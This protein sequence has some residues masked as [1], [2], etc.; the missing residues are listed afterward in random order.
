[1]LRK[2]LLLS[3]RIGSPGAGLAVGDSGGRRLY[4]EAR[5]G[6]MSIVVPLEVDQVRQL[7][8]TGRSWLAEHDQVPTCSHRLNAASVQV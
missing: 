5:T 4:L 7:V 2:L 3:S 1:M 8:A 6:Q